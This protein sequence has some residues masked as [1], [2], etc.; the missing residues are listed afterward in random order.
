MNVSERL[1]DAMLATEPERVHMLTQ[2][3]LVSYG[4]AGIDSA[5]QQRRAIANEARDVQEANKLGLDRRH[6]AKIS[7]RELVRRSSYRLL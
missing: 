5:E 7:W 4:L 3:E 6:A 2:A 1:A